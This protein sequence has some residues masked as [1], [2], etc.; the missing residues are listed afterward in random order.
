[1][2]WSKAQAAKIAAA[3]TA[4]FDS[5]PTQGNLLICIGAIRA[6]G[7]FTGAPGSGTWSQ[8]ILNNADGTYPGVAVWYKI[9]GAGESATVTYTAD[10]SGGVGICIIEYTNTGVAN[11][12]LDNQI[13][14]VGSSAAPASG[15]LTCAQSDELKLLAI[16]V[17]STTA[18]SNWTNGF[19]EVGT[20]ATGSGGGSSRMGVADILGGGTSDGGCTSGN[21]AWRAS[22]VAF[23][24]LAAGG[25]SIPVAMQNYRQRR[26]NANG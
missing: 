9:A 19:G 6:N 14:A 15:S 1:M 23:K 10:V 3:K 20:V 17:R 4:T 2:A 11:A 24:I 21:A 7:T 13:T 22:Q 25:L 12:L 5:I 8:A 16:E 26:G 18:F